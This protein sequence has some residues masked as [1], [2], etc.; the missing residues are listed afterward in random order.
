MFDTLKDQFSN[1]ELTY[2]KDALTAD[3]S[4]E[5]A[6]SP[7]LIKAAATEVLTYK[8]F[9]AASDVALRR[10][11]IL[12]RAASRIRAQE[13]RQ[14]GSGT[15]LKR[16]G[17]AADKIELLSHRTPYSYFFA[18]TDVTLKHPRFDGAT[19]GPV[20]RVV[21]SMADAVTVLPYDPVRKRVLLIEQFRPG[22]F[23]RGDRAPW[24]IEPIAGRIDVGEVPEETARREAIEEANIALKDLH[25]VSEYYPS[26]GAITEFLTSY[27]GIA[28]LP[29]DV[30]GVAGLDS[31]QEDIASTLLP[32]DDLLELADQG[33]LDTG[34]LLVS[35]LWLAR[36]HGRL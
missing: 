7:E 5:I 28:D 24:V 22:P 2:L 30:V 14:L 8:A 9:E 15:K 21:F 19:S 1:D 12:V 16:Q 23:V 3:G 10:D 25:L 31:E 18:A 20:Q 4:S 36:H 33:A 27:I 6:L 34:P 35:A 11:V 32:L 13:P 17:E 26:P 29:D